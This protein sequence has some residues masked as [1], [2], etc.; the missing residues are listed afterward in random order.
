[1]AVSNTDTASLLPHHPWWKYG[2]IG[3]GAGFMSAFFGI[4]GGVVMVPALTFWL[5]VPVKIAVGTSLIAILGFTLVGICI[6]MFH[7][8]EYIIWDHVGLMAAGSLAGVAIGKRMHVKASDWLLKLLFALMLIF[9]ITKLCNLVSFGDEAH[10]AAYEMVLDTIPLQSDSVQAFILRFGLATVLGLVAG[11]A[12]ALLGAGGGVIYVPGLMILFAVYAKDIHWA[13]ATS[14][15]TVVITSLYGGYL[16]SRAGNV[17]K[18]AVK[19]LLVLG[20]F[21][22]IGGSFVAAVTSAHSL[23]VLFAALLGTFA[24][25]MI[26]SGVRDL[27]RRSQKTG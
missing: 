24:L 16:H 20:I 23:L 19:P 1:M 14:M 22:A 4:G 12:A 15:A 11:M 25:Q 17:V 27:L 2:A 26:V 3:I 9:G 18:D 8:P 21:G 5:R 6:E 13:R 10:P 7:T